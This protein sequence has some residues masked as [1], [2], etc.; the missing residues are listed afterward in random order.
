MFNFA[1][2][3]SASV[4]RR[5][6]VVP[7]AVSAA[8]PGV[9]VMLVL[10]LTFS[11]G[12]AGRPGPAHAMILLAP[13]PVVRSVPQ[14]AHLAEPIPPRLF[15]APVI[16]SLPA[17]LVEMA[18]IP[19][20]QIPLIEVAHPLLAGPEIARLPVAPPP[21]LRIDNLA[22]PQAPAKVADSPALAI[23][24]SSGFVPI[25][26]EAPHHPRGQP[27]LPGGFED[28]TLLAASQ[29]H[30]ADVAPVAPVSRSVEILSKPRPVYTEEAR[31][32][33]I[34]GEVLLEVLFAASGQARVL[35]TIRGLGHGLDESA[36]AAAEAIHFRPAERGGIAADSTAI[37][38]IV[39]QLAF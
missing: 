22:S 18:P 34:E 30:R 36:I 32:Q 29:P 37:V 9:A 16:Q 25:A 6:P 39:F 15:R 7:F 11:D 3:G 17:S 10:A 26:V 4:V 1:A 21:P 23:A 27:M 2:S 31:R 5:R 13:L 12:I 38:H 33:R 8:I 24:R 35:G 19:A 20:L 14:A 28:A